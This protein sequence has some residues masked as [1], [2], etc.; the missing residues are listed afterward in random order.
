M[1]EER[2]FTVANPR[3]FDGNPFE[4]AERAVAQLEGLAAILEEALVPAELMARNAEM[5]RRLEARQP[6]RGDDWAETPQG[7]YWAKIAAEVRELQ[8]HLRVCKR[9]SGFD[10]RHP[11]R[12]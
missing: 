10:P 8:V 3:D 6:P 12:D 1:Q 9:A 11:P 4:V 7:R 2:T 5:S